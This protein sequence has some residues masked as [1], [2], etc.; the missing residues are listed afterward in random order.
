MGE[1]ETVQRRH[2]GLLG[3]VLVTVLIGVGAG[4]A[5]AP[6]SAFACTA[7][8]NPDGSHTC[9]D[10]QMVPCPTVFNG[11]TSGFSV[12]FIPQGSPNITH[13][14]SLACPGSGLVET[15][16]PNASMP[17]PPSG[18]Q[19]AR[20]DF[21]ATCNLMGG[22]A[23]GTQAATFSVN[24]FD[25]APPPGGGGGTAGGSAL[26][27]PNILDVIIASKV[28]V[29]AKTGTGEVEVEYVKPE[30]LDMTDWLLKTFFGAHPVKPKKQSLAVAS[31]A[32]RVI[33]G[34]LSDAHVAAGQKRTVMHL[35]LNG[36]GRKALGALG[37]LSTTAQGT[38]SNSAGSTPLT[39]KLKLVAK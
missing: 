31:P 17:A 11:T 20:D 7:T 14:F 39:T 8:N 25:P 23:G 22:C 15:F 10:T 33:I 2:W 26:V 28:K 12:L 29:D 34:T 18:D 27:P 5:I 19:T 32:K 9:M 1:G 21:V 30:D 16:D 24:Y 35:K 13:T 4:S 6:G 38:L 37:K 3:L 36:K